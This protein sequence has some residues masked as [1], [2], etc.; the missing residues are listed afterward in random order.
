MNVRIKNKGSFKNIL[1]FFRKSKD[2]KIDAILDRYGRMGVDVLSSA[3]PLRTGTT[4][5]SWRYE[6]TRSAG[7]S[8]INWYNDNLNKGVN[9]A[10]ILQYGHGTGT[11]GYVRGIDYINPAL[12]PVMEEAAIELWKEVTSV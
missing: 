8:S 2:M 3:T 9:V 1:N 12:R 4:S 7:G 6:I 5:S 11:G 10:L